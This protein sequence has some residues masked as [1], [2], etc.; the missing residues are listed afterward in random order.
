MLEVKSTMKKQLIDEMNDK[1][2]KKDNN[3]LRG[4]LIGMIASF[5]ALIGLFAWGIARNPAVE[6]DSSTVAVDYVSEVEASVIATNE[7]V[8]GTVE[9]SAVAA[10]SAVVADSAE[11]VEDTEEEI[12]PPAGAN[13]EEDWRLI[14]V[15]KWNKIPEDYEVTTETIE[16]G[17]QVDERIVKDLEEMLADCREAGYSP[18]ICSSFR[19]TE[20]QQ[21]LF[22]ADVRK[23]MNQGYSREEA[24]ILTAESVAVPATSEHEIG[25]AVDIVY[26]GYQQLD[27][28]QADNETQ[29]WLMANCQNYG[30]IL[31]YPEDK[32]DITGITYEPWH[33][34]Y[35][36]RE[37]AQYIMENEI[38][39]E[40]YLGR[41]EQQEESEETQ[42][43][44]IEEQRN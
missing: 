5:V 39:L 15:N 21:Q 23:F 12:I 6:G 38:C 37:A 30:F 28:A 22:D 16:Y 27:D 29:Q 14:L 4:S 11:S 10:D 3:D 7:S 41:T 40:E 2:M 9:E 8:A 31:R 18:L 20:K 43:D 32:T 34:R 42:E 26:S 13:A 19:S 1:R 24:E 17:H 44:E 35:V 33:Y 25:L 36:G